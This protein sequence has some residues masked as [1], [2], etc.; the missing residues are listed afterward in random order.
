MVTS[1]TPASIMLKMFSGALRG[2]SEGVAV[3]FIAGF[4]AAFL[5]MVGASLGGSGFLGV[6]GQRGARGAFY[7]KR[8]MS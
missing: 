3:P 2:L 5:F 4:H 8:S 6:V 7:V 1:A